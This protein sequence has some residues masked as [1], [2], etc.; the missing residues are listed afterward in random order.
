M[1]TD[2]MGARIDAFLLQRFDP[3]WTD[4]TAEQADQCRARI[5]DV[6]RELVRSISAREAHLRDLSRDVAGTLTLSNGETAD[7]NLSMLRALRQIKTETERLADDF[8]AEAGMHGA[9]YPDL[10]AAWGITR[11]GARKRWSH[12]VSALNPDTYRG[13]EPI[14]FEAFGGEARVSFHPDDGGWWWIATAANRRTA[15]APEGVT[16]DTS[17]EASAAAGAFLAANTTTDGVT[18]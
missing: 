8:A 12:T 9:N 6:A 7:W 15:E 11:Q 17:E 18:T 2:E 4:P 10:G 13:R 16:Y 5:E 14:H 1:T 3:P